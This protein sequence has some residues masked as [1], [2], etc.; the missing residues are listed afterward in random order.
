MR[1]QAPF[2]KLVTDYVKNYQKTEELMES[3]RKESPAYYDELKRI[4]VGSF[5]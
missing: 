1:K 4:L 3:K 5:I 2:L